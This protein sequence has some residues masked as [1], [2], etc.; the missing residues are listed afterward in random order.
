MNHLKEFARSGHP[1]TLLSAFLYFDISF[2]VWVLLGPLGT[3]VA[4]DLHLSPA[5]KGLM[6]AVPL[7]GGSLFR[8]IRLVSGVDEAEAR[9]LFE[10]SGRDVKTAI[11]MGLTGTDRDE[12]KRRLDAA[13]GVLRR[14]LPDLVRR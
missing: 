7:L 10:A 14:A 5:Q 8:L 12:A 1:P 13:G 2:M 6:A 4:E 9:R 11:F 3:Y